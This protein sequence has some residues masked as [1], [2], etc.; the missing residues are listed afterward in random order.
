M[1]SKRNLGPE[2]DKKEFEKLFAAIDDCARIQ[3]VIDTADERGFQIIHQT[4]NNFKENFERAE[5]YREERD[6][7]RGKVQSLEGEIERLKNETPESDN[8][9]RAQTRNSRHTTPF[10]TVSAASTAASRP[11]TR[12]KDPDEFSGDCTKYEVWKG[13]METKLYLD[14]GTFDNDNEVAM[15]ILSRLDDDAAEAFV[16]YR[17][18]GRITLSSFEI[19]RRLDSLY[20]IR[21]K[22]GDAIAKLSSLTQA[23]MALKDF[24]VKYQ[25]LTMAAGWDD[26]TAKENL[27]I[28][29]SHTNYQLATARRHEPFTTVV[30]HLMETANTQT[31]RDRAHGNYDSKTRVGRSGGRTWGDKRNDGGTNSSSIAQDHKGKGKGTSSVTPS[32]ARS[33]SDVKCYNCNKTGHISRDCKEPKRARVNRVTV[34]DSGNSEDSGNE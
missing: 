12:A 13:K 31:A 17:D 28:K 26:E 25:S 8:E 24:L 27:L 10:T 5:R 33:M 20:G 15:Y 29:L 22:R 11:R 16:S 30:A 4:L 7:L 2:V 9:T 19:W 23:G 32:T 21:N 1:P 34:V 14:A 3:D 18:K 6:R